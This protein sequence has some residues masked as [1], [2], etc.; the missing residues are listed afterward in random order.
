[1]YFIFFA[2]SS[3]FAAE[4]RQ[5]PTEQ[6]QA[7]TLYIFHTPIVMLQAK[8]GQTTPEE[9][10][11]RIHNTLRKFTQ[12]DVREPIKILPVTRYNQQ[13]RLLLI[14]LLYTSPSPRDA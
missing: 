2:V 5:E 12:A 1:M 8:F 6:E 10:V 9:R 7:R 13:G 14:C 3:T 11:L 4:P